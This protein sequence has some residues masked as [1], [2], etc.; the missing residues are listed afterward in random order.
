M[1]SLIY[2]EEWYQQD[3][4]NKVYQEMMQADNVKFLTHPV[5]LTQWNEF[6]SKYQEPGFQAVLLKERSSEEVLKEWADYLTAAQKE[7]LQTNQ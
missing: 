7:Y 1:N 4:Y 3:E 2:E 5:W 6:R